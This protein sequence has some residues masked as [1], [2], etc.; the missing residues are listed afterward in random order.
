MPNKKMS[1]LSKSWGGCSHPQP[2]GSATP[3]IQFTFGFS[4]CSLCTPVH[5]ELCHRTWCCNA[6]SAWK[7]KRDSLPSIFSSSTF[8]KQA[9]CHVPRVRPA[10]CSTARK[11]IDT[12][13]GTASEESC[14][15]WNRCGI[16][17]IHAIKNNEINSGKLDPLKLLAY[18]NLP[19]LLL[20]FH[21]SFCV[22]IFLNWFSKLWAL[23]FLQKRFL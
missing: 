11:S 8:R 16:L 3:V 10:V 1:Q 20:S 18:K 4:I 22:D 23:W 7:A 2:L 17:I 12:A 15:S 5:A 13:P 9:T 14:P 21:F 6:C 19:S